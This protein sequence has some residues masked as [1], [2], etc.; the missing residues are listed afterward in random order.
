LWILKLGV[1]TIRVKEEEQRIMGHIW[2][3]GPVRK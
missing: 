2:N 1:E 3:L